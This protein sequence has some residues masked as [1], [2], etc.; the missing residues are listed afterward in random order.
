LLQAEADESNAVLQP[1]FHHYPTDVAV[2]G[3]MASGLFTSRCL[4]TYW[5]QKYKAATP[6][7]QQTH[8]AAAIIPWS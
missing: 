4:R 2:T 7:H 8:A 1:L 5:R 3:P 6:H